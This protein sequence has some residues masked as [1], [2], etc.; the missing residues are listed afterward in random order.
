MEPTSS[1]PTDDPKNKIAFR[2][3]NVPPAEPNK[4]RQVIGV[5][6]HQDKDAHARSTLQLT[7]PETFGL[8]EVDSTY[9][10]VRVSG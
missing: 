7:D 5:V 4:P 10:L 9:Q 1:T 2:V 3:T 8:L 6:V